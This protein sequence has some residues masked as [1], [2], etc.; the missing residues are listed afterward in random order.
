M[1]K[2][3]IATITATALCLSFGVFAGEVS[4]SEISKKIQSIT[5]FK[6]KSVTDSESGMYE[7]VTG[8][9]IFY[10]TKDGEYLLSGSIHKFEPGLLN[11]TNE[12]KAEFAKVDIDKLRSTFIT[13][14]APEEK[15]EVIVFFDT[16]CGYCQKMHKEISQYNAAGITVHYAMYPRNGISKPSANGDVYTPTY[17][18]MMG[19]VCS[20]DPET[21]MNMVMRGTG[22]PPK[23]CANS[24]KEHYELGT[25]L[26]VRGT[27][28]VYGMDGKSVM[29]GYGPAKTLL[30]KLTEVKG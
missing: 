4:K 27:P 28:A 10:S 8:K 2:S 19:I 22:L 11:L 30:Q 3:I 25:Q 15:H 12:R 17:N 7:I 5:P 24:I 14:K 9:G 23:S 18:K 1:K 16:S 13:Y 6:V 29:G 26:G 21:S 20:D